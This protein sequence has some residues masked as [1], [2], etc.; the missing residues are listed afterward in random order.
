M[1][2]K[3]EL[4][5]Y[6]IIGLILVLLTAGIITMLFLNISDYTKDQSNELVCGLDVAKIVSEQRLLKDKI[7]VERVPRCSPDIKYVKKI[8]PT[9]TY[10][11]V[12]LSELDKE[13]NQCN[14]TF[15]P[16]QKSYYNYIC[17]YL[18]LDQ[19]LDKTKLQEAYENNKDELDFIDSTYFEILNY[20]IDDNLLKKDSPLIVAYRYETYKLAIFNLPIESGRPMFFL[21]TDKFVEYRLQQSKD[22]GRLKYVG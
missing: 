8:V 4:G 14:F 9:Q 5:F 10:E 1:N 12:F 21:N 11:K 19:D 22:E 2:K 6:T 20:G 15:S 7:T 17:A 13:L 16:L 3:A 18:Y